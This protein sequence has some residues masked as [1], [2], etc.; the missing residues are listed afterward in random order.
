MAD[1]DVYESLPSA[2]PLSISC[3]AGATAGIAEHC[4]MF[5]IDSV[6]VRPGHH[7]VV[8]R[9]AP[10]SH[11]SHPR[12]PGSGPDQPTH[13]AESSQGHSKAFAGL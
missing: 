8:G 6:K 1:P 5:P 2:T 12:G 4:L 7:S 3:L 9:F 10:S 13:E 11:R